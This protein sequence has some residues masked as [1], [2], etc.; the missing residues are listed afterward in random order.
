VSNDRSYDVYSTDGNLSLHLDSGSL[1]GDEAYLVIM[2]PGAV[3]GPLPDELVL[4]GDSYDVTASGALVTLEKP[5][6]LKLR[7]DQALVR[8]SSAPQ[9]LGIYRWNPVSETWQAVPGELDEGRKAMAAPVTTLGTYA[10][11]ASPGSWTWPNAVFL[12]VVL[13]NSES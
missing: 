5:A 11:L 9:G 1:P 8:S 2:P 13:R 10:L 6:V 4:V 12:P 7:Y 3:P